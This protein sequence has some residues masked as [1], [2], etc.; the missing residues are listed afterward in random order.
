M[1]RTDSLLHPQSSS[2]AVVVVDVG[3][4]QDSL[5]SSSLIQSRVLS[6]KMKNRLT[7]GKWN[8]PVNFIISPGNTV[9]RIRYVSTN[10]LLLFLLLLLLLLLMINYWNLFSLLECLDLFYWSLQC[11]L[12]RGDPVLGG[13][14]CSQCLGPGSVGDE[15]TLATWSDVVVERLRRFILHQAETV[16]CWHDLQ[17]GTLRWNMT[18]RT[19]ARG[20]KIMIN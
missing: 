1:I 5:G 9:F 20:S 3:S 14:P 18:S 15:G 11:S 6:S 19:W 12:S 10:K 2:R 8:I 13:A 16:P 7:P 4:L 17:F